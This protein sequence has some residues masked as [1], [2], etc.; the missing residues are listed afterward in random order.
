MKM[1]K[2]NSKINKFLSH[3][4]VKAFLLGGITILIGGICSALGIWDYNSDPYFIGK[5]IALICSVIL[6]VFILAYYSTYETNERKSAFIYQKQNEAFEE[7]M[8][9]LMS[10][11]KQT[12]EGANQVIRNIV[13]TGEANLRLWNFDK[14][15]FWVC[16]NVYVLLCKI[17]NGKDFEVVYDRL[18]EEKQEKTIV[19][20][21]YANRNLNRPSV[22]GKPRKIKEDEFHDSKLFFINR[23]D[24]EVIIGTDEIDKEFGYNPQNRRTRNKKK[25]NQYIAIPVFCHDEK[26][27]GLLEIICLEKSSLGNSEKEIQENVSKYFIA[28]TFLLLLLHKLEKALTVQ[29]GNFSNSANDK[30]EIE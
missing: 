16:Q 28:Y 13:E 6:Y 23:S 8:S 7:F 25:Y 1:R 22:Y 27:V 11:C 20:N 21:S 5:I 14:A 17:G 2:K 30:S 18:M 3:P 10:L 12:A 15:C 19:L 29:P 9:G 26:M 24:I 4:F